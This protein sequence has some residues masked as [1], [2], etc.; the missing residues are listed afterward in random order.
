MPI[1]AEP[2][3]HGSKRIL[4]MPELVKPSPISDAVE[5]GEQRGISDSARALML[6]SD[7][8][9]DPL[10]W[11]A[12]RLGSMSAWW[13][14]VPFAHWIVSA[15]A[16]RLLV[17]LGTHTGVSYSA[18]CQAVV[19]EGLATRCH[20]VDTWRGDAHAGTYGDEVL[21]ELRRFHDER[22]GAFSTLLQCTF[23][24]ALGRIEDGSIDLLH[25]DGLHTYEAVR[26]D[27][28]SWLP[29]LSNQAV[30][31]FHDINERKGD[32][33]VWRLW[34]ELR[35][36]YLAFEFLHGHALG[37]LAVGERP[38]AA[39]IALC[40]LTNPT[41]IATVRMRFARLGEHW[42]VDTRE[43]MLL[44]GIGQYSVAATQA[45]QE[46][47]GL[48]AQATQ[49]EQEIAGLRAQADQAEQEIAGLRAQADQAEQ[50]IARLRAQA[51]QAKQEIAGLLAQVDQAEQDIAGLRAQADQAEQEIAGLRA[52]A[53]QAKQDIAGLRAQVDQAEQDIAGL[54]AQADQAEQ[55]I[56]G[57]RAQAAWAEGN[58]A[59]V[60]AEADEAAA[61]REKEA[62]R[63]RVREVTVV[64]REMVTALTR[65]EQAESLAAGLEMTLAQV[66]A[67]RDSVLASTAWRATRPAR[68]VGKHIPYRVRRVMRGVAKLGWWTVT[69]KLP[70][71]LRE[72]KEMLQAGVATGPD[73]DRATLLHSK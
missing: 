21:D 19:R 55:D 61:L 6:L 59:R 34:S 13:Q 45:E 53:A 5:F 54:R 64:Q 31:M 30:V 57:L 71:K 3:D 29:K 68:V 10:F 60:R 26:H 63:L 2:V 44:H 43:R 46:I 33:G 9:L 70:R 27:F 28:E 1:G 37:V 18:F 49:A 23:D 58:L 72:R 25:I 40:E 38:P 39:V 11:R 24:D 8:C 67:E 14:H 66:R 4:D 42:Q 36:R 50:D 41:A 56:A 15:T 16:P 32:F 69:M 65:A 7:P 62:T 20:A 35:Q 48:R 17:E 22:F 52:Q 12:E 47:A 73:S 51:A